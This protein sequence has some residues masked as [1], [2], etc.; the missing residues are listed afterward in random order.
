MHITAHDDAMHDGMNSSASVVIPLGSNV[1]GEYAPHSRGRVFEAGRHLVN[2][3]GIYSS[4][5]EKRREILRRLHVADPRSFG[6]RDGYTGRELRHPLHG[7]RIE[8]VFL[9]QYADN[10]H[11]GRH[12]P[13]ANGDALAIQIFG[14]LDSGS[15][16]RVHH[17]MTK[18]TAEESRHAD[19]GIITGSREVSMSSHGHFRDVELEATTHATE[20]LGGGKR[21]NTKVDPFCP[22]RTGLQRINSIIVSECGAK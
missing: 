18:S 22:H 2:E 15:H 20:N 8:S 19:K 11:H 12:T 16:I 4:G 21:L 13:F 9:G 10:P 1:V 14:A 7:T 5:F 17:S 6:H 3:R